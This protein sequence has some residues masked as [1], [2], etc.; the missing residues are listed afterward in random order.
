MYDVIVIGGGIGGTGVAAL[1]AQ[2][3]LKVLLLEKNR[4]VGGRCTSYER[5]G[6]KVPTYVHAFARADQGPCGD[7]ARK[8]QEPLEWV[9]ERVAVFNLKGKEIP[10]TI[11]AGGRDL[12]KALGSMKLGWWELFRA[13]GLAKD[14]RSSMTKWERE[15]DRLDIQSWISRHTENESIHAL[16][17][18]ISAAT[19]VVPPW[20][21]S[22]GEYLHI[23]RGMAK[24]G[25][26]GYPVEE[27]SAIP[28]TY[29]RGFR[30]A[31]G[32]LRQ[33]RVRRITVQDN[34]ARGVEL[35][36]GE[37]IGARA[38]ISNAGV[39]TT[40]LDLVDHNHFDG[41]YLKSVRNLKSSWSALALK[42]ALDKKITPLK[43]CIYIPT[44][45]PGGYFRQLE[46]NQ[47][48]EELTLWVTIPSN[49]IPSLVPEGKQLICAGSL[50]PYR[51]ELDW[52]PYINKGFETLEKLFPEI[53]KYALWKESVT[54]ADLERWVAREG[55][56]IEVAQT[57]GQVGKDRPP[58]SSPIQGLYWV[59]S[60]VGRRAVGVELAA[61]SALRCAEELESRFRERGA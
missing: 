49:A 13:S 17:A 4:Q 60:D 40:V 20:E 27:C 8:I 15:F 16:I 59:G 58:I 7:L 28:E 43:A 31:G 53:P 6:F 26:G 2:K 33:E 23:L 5:E 32:E 61:E 3:K 12:L 36:N 45:D 51:P 44:L 19:F 30:K 41:D 52:T 57:V 25:A 47:V 39:K 46:Q 50:L 11:G 18:F 34:Q 48:P 22:T 55:T 38:V 56:L 10:L 24:A 1:L 37:F 9:R 21:G 29:L 35:E 54:P 42:V 14:I